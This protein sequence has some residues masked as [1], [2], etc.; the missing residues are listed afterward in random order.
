MGKASKTKGNSY[1]LK[2][3]KMLTDWWG[4][5]NFSRVPASGG[6]H[7]ADDQRVA[8]DI[9]PPPKADFPFVIEC[10]KREEWTIEH[11]LLDIGQPR[12]WWNQVVTDA[13]RVKLVP[14][15]MFSRNRAKN[16]IMIPYTI[17]MYEELSSK[18]K[19]TMITTVTFPNIR[20]EPQVFE[21]IVTTYETFTQLSPDTYKMYA[22]G[23]EWDALNEVDDEPTEE[24]FDVDS[25]QMK[26][27]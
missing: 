6:L 19:D 23:L 24:A 26:D 2:I 7:W 9:I 11:I 17:E 12:E 10:K 18:G 20:K 15:L 8:G 22:K 1:E 25:I 13:R 27:L 21:V 5:G 16:F 3:A 4:G 14:L